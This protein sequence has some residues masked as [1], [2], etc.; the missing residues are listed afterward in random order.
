MR[1]LDRHPVAPSTEAAGAE[2]LIREARRLRRRRW[3][4]GTLVVV[5]AGAAGGLGYA[6]AGGRPLAQRSAPARRTSTATVT[7]VGGPLRHPYGLAVAP[8]GDLYVVDVG[9]DQILRR[10]PDGK[11]QV[12]A[13]DGRQGFSGDGGPATKAELRLT[14]F[15][16]VAVARDGT[17]YFSDSGND[18]V[19][20][21]LPDG[22]VETVAGDG[23]TGPHGGEILRPTPALDASIGQP[24]GL[25]IGPDGDLYVAAGNVVRLTPAGA[26]EWVAGKPLTG[27]RSFRTLLPCSG[28][29]CNPAGEPDFMW[30]YQ[31]AFDTAGDLFVTTTNFDLC[32]VT[33]DGRLRYLGGL[34][35]DG[36]PAALAGAPNGSVVEAARGGLFRLPHAGRLAV[37]K[38]HSDGAGSQ[39]VP[40]NLD[41]ALGFD[42]THPNFFIGG[43]GVAVGPGGAIYADTNTG[44]SWT[45]VSALVEVTPAGKVLTLWR[46]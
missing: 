2:A 24:K 31:L 13:G 1:L 36:G 4:I 18:R 34:R 9:R 37:P 45:T 29:R 39:P 46:S 8:D 17:V 20:A 28:T 22:R 15:S 23:R 19:R 11:F 26:L 33:A 7:A 14:W 35:G 27:A 10:L 16:G 38:P 32:E 42:H 30:P 25:A 12:V 3:A 41:G 44:N 6:L 21:V 43:D 5:L 40:G